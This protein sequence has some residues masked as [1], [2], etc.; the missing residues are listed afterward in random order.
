[1]EQTHCMA[2]A[3]HIRRFLDLCDGNWHNCVYVRCA[4]CKAISSCKYPDFLIHPDASGIPCI[5]P[6][7]DAR[8]LFSR[9][10]AEECLLR[11]TWS[12]FLVLYRHYLA[13]NKISEEHCVCISLLRL[14]E[15]ACYDW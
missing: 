11:I 1:M 5:L 8:I 7:S 13:A 10:E 3:K 6:F 2:D 4:S 15:D 9:M 12:D 14:Q